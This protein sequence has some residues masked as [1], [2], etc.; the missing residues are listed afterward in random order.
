MKGRPTLDVVVGQHLAAIKLLASK[1]DTLMNRGGAFL[2]LNRGLDNIDGNICP[3]SQSDGLA[4]QSLY[5]KLY[6]ASAAGC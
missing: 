1:D 6:I 2:D 5:K 3:E 4:R